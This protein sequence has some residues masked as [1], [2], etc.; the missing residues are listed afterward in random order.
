[1]TDVT[2]GQSTPGPGF[3]SFNE[4]VTMLRRGDIALAVGILTILVVLILPLPSVVLDRSFLAVLDHAVHPHP[5]DIA[6]HPGPARILVVPDDPADFDHAA[7]V[8]QPRIDAA[9]PGAWSRRHRG[10]RPCHRGLRQLRDGRQFRHRHHRVCHPRDREL[11]RHHQG[12]GPHRRS[13]RA[14]S[15]R[16][17]AGQAD[18]HR[19]R[20]LGRLDRREGRA[21]AAQGARGRKRLLRRHGRCVEIRSRRCGRRSSGRLHQRHRRHG[22]RHRAARHDLR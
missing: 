6:V 1:M 11:R 15:P 12:P 22:N 17:D 13:G 10:R 4:I 7:A 20:S 9:D 16:R 8:A 21:G 3:P 19:R 14:L 5:D 18:G 2:A